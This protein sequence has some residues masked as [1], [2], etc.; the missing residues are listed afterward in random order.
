M[1]APHETIDKFGEQPEIPLK[2]MFEGRANFYETPA[3]EVAKYTDP[4]PD[5]AKIIINNGL[6]DHT[7]WLRREKISDQQI[8][9]YRKSGHGNPRLDLYIQFVDK[10]KASQLDD[11]AK[12][13]AVNAFFTEMLHYDQK[14]ADSGPKPDRIQTTY[15]TLMRG[16]GVCDDMAHIKFVTLKAVGVDESKMRIVDGAIWDRAQETGYAHE[17]LM[18]NANN[19]NIILNASSTDTLDKEALRTNI[20]WVQGAHDLS[21]ES[22]YFVPMLSIGADNKMN[23]YTIHLDG[24]NLIPVHASQWETLEPKG[25]Q[26]IGIG[27]TEDHSSNININAPKDLKQ[28]T[29]KEY[30]IAFEVHDAMVWAHNLNPSRT[31]ELAA[32]NTTID[33]TDAPIP[34]ARYDSRPS[35]RGLMPSFSPSAESTGTPP[36]ANSVQTATASPKKPVLAMHSP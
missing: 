11:R 36:P 26:T 8:A 10:L 33:P 13:E 31:G 23:A 17:V 18:V 1:P 32:Q 21:Y 29:M 20:G 30:P 15:D 2:D 28:L 22:P 25:R 12:V 24:N 35:M 16:S 27:W 7:S 19:A 14:K 34:T 4:G 6:N 5:Y 3:G 9:Q